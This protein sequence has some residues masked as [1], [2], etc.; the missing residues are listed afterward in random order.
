MR[1]RGSHLFLMIDY[2]IGAFFTMSLLVFGVTFFAIT[3]PVK[4]YEWKA[5]GGAYTG[6]LV[7]LEG[8][9]R[10]LRADYCA[11]A[12]AEA[13]AVAQCADQATVTQR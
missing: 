2:A 5:L 11:H 4:S 6:F 8:S 1:P 10:D 7:K 3:G 13:Q 12:D 9:A